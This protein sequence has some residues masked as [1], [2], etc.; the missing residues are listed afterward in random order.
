MY[1]FQRQR[2]THAVIPFLADTRLRWHITVAPG[3]SILMIS[4]CLRHPSEKISGAEHE[5]MLALVSG[6]ITE[7]AHNNTDRS[8]KTRERWYRLGRW[9]PSKV[10]RRL[11]LLRLKRK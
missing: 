3:S 11:R 8:P 10:L 2:S 6:G 9:G 5:L 1:K 7:S 4:T